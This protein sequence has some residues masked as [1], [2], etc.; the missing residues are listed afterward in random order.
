MADHADADGG[1]TMRGLRRPPSRLVA[2]ACA[3]ALS[4]S[5]ST[6]AMAQSPSPSPG[7]PSAAN[8]PAYEW[9]EVKPSWFGRAVV[10]EVAASPTGRAVAFGFNPFKDAWARVFDSKDGRKWRSRALPQFHPRRPLRAV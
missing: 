4:V 5:L 3:L 6:Q 7:A 8:V 10:G 2:F 1:L 9:R